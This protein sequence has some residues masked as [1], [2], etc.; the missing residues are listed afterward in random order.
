M[1]YGNRHTS[2]SQTLSPQPFSN[3]PSDHRASVL[4]N[5]VDVMIS[6]ADGFLTFMETFEG[7]EAERCLGT[8]EASISISHMLEHLPQTGSVTI[9]ITQS[10]HDAT[11]F[12]TD[13]NLGP[14]SNCELLELNYYPFYRMIGEAFGFSFYLQGQTTLDGTCSYLPDRISLF[15]PYEHAHS[16]IQL[17]SNTRSFFVNRL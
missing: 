3:A 13:Y 2:V 9:T 6:N 11:S 12:T 17:K 1:C 14:H 7:V 15:L 4:L 10:G 16:N 5:R 8:L